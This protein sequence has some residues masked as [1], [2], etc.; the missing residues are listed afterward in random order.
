MYRYISIMLFRNTWTNLYLFQKIWAIISRLDQ[1]C[2]KFIFSWVYDINY[3]WTPKSD[4]Y[5]EFILLNISWAIFTY[6][7]LF[8]S[9][10]QHGIKIKFFVKI[11][12][13]TAFRW[14]YPINLIYDVNISQLI[15]LLAL[16]P[17]VRNSIEVL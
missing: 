8:L 17:H 7:Q 14:Y 4:K 1:S 3:S 9:E 5:L 11:S 16:E 6:C 13:L 10:I 12:F 2:L 15:F